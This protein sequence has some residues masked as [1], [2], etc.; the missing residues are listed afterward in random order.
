LKREVSFLQ[1]HGRIIEFHQSTLAE[2][3]HSIKINDSL[4]SMNDCNDSVVAESMTDYFLYN[5]VS[6]GIEAISNP[7]YQP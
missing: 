4:Y 1:Q 5:R 7:Y 3:S 2:D 6:V